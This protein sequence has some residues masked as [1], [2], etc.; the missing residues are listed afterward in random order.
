[1]NELDESKALEFDFPEFLTFIARKHNKKQL[2]TDIENAFANGYKKILEEKFK[3]LSNNQDVLNLESLNA[4]F[5]SN[6]SFIE[7]EVC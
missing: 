7:N 6:A 2:E 1:M 5:D 3:I 4:F